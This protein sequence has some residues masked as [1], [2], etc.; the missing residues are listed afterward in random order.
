MNKLAMQVLIAATVAITSAA[1]ADNT[2]ILK[3]SWVEQYKNQILIT[4]DCFVDVVHKKPNPP[5]KDGDLHM[6]VR[7]PNDV[8]LSG[9]AEIMNAGTKA[10][11]PGVTKAHAVEGS[12]DK[13]TIAGVWRLWPEHAGSDEIHS[14]LKPPTE[15]FDTTNPD[16]LF[17]IHPITK[18]DSVNLLKTF[19]PIDALK[20]SP[21]VP[22]DADK[23][24]GAYAQTNFSISYDADTIKMVVNGV[25]YNYVKFGLELTEDPIKADDGYFAY[26]SLLDVKGEMQARRVRT[27]FVSG[28][29]AADVVSKLGK[30]DCRVVLG[31]PRVDLALVSWRVDQAENHGNKD[32]L[33]WSLPYEMVVVG[34]YDKEK[35]KSDE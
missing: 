27:V 12:G 14:Q 31:I 10:G 22:K 35:C 23:A 15:A 32:P 13:Q 16:H 34:V 21:F 18:L 19:G 5:N 24:F 9:V 20:K 26:G 1:V 30:G 6:A 3:R 8:D 17:E 28:T 4:A 7:C 11:T 33:S 2:L 29:H 25:G